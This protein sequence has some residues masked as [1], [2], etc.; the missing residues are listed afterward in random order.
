MVKVWACCT[1]CLNQAVPLPA[2][3]PRCWMCWLT[4]RR[5]ATLRVTSAST[6]TRRRPTPLRGSPAMV[7]I[8]L[9]IRD[10]HCQLTVVDLLYN[11]LYPQSNTARCTMVINGDQGLYIDTVSVAPCS[12]ADRHPLAADHGARGADLLCVPAPARQGRTCRT[13]DLIC[14]LCRF[15]CGRLVV[16]DEW[17]IAWA[18][19]RKA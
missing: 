19:T 15:V 18:C 13:T 11:I 12:R 10:N 16:G 6:A 3:R 8:P 7:S 14:H 1:R 5:A 4:A 17:R 2:C 9:Q